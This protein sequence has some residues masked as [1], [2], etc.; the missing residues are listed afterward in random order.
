M[1]AIPLLIIFFNNRNFSV[2]TTQ[3]SY[4]NMILK[5]GIAGIIY[6]CV[7]MVFGYFVAWQFEDLRIFYSGN[8]EKLS[9]FRQMHQNFAANKIIF[10]FQ[11]VR[12]ILFGVFIIPLRTMINKKEV[13][14][15]GVC[16][17]S[18][19]T[20]VMLIIPNALFP[21]TVRFAHLLEMVSSM[22]L[23]GVIAGNLIWKR[24]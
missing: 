10:P 17:L 9:F 19:C 20:A 23:F 6:L 16:L 15:T 21:D 3:I 12:G 13:F 8:S 11:I 14:L 18:L 5:L 24:N 4:R 22:L 2:K 7:Y 1:A